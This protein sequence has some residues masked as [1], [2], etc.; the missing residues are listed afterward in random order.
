[1]TRRE[2]IT[3][4]VTGAVM[5]VSVTDATGMVYRR[6]SRLIAGFV[7]ATRAMLRRVGQ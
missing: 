7:T 5:P 4:T 6:R 3:V 2:G 1:M